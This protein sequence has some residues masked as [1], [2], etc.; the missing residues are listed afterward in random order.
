[1][2][3]QAARRHLLAIVLVSAA[4]CVDQAATA[5]PAVRAVGTVAA[6][7]VD[8]F[9]HKLGGTVRQVRL[10]Q[11]HLVQGQAVLALASPLHASAYPASQQTAF[12]FSLPPP[13][14]QV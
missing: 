2:T 5:S 11:I 3:H 10:P 9:A 4:L 14:D 1:M 13:L 12:R 8:R 7:F 6:G